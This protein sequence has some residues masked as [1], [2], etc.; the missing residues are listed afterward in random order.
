MVMATSSLGHAQGNDN[1]FLCSK[2]GCLILLKSMCSKTIN[3]SFLLDDSNLKLL[4]FKDLLRLAKPASL[5]T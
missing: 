1:D 3:H 5:F 4:P 2:Y